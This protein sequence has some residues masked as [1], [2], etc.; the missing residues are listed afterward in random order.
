[1]D[2][3]PTKICTKCKQGKP[4]T[5]EFFRP[6]KGY[7]NNLNSW[8]RKCSRVYENQRRKR[9]DVRAHDT[10]QQRLR[11]QQ[12]PEAFRTK[13]RARYHRY[14]PKIRAR[15]NERYRTD[16]EFRRRR[17]AEHRRW[18]ERNRDYVREYASRRWREKK[19]ILKV[20]K[21]Q[22]YEIAGRA[23]YLFKKYG[24]TM[25]EYEQRLAVQG[26][27]CA[28]S[29]DTPGGRRLHFDHD[30]TTKINRGFLCGP[31]NR[32]LGL[33][34][35]DPVRMANAIAY[36]QHWNGKQNLGDPALTQA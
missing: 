7:A 24:I 18:A 36:L 35:H 28:I 8:C 34:K 23:R 1:M 5:T 11:R 26:G 13:R 6:H 19:S 16:P 31:C 22:H 30:H 14:K 33:F 27:K 17:R 9:P 12:N 25:E 3:A 29:H 32:A 15:A 21:H 10:E 20:K 2:P 4:A